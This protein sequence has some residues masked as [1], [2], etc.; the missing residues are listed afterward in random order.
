MQIE[1][2]GS[3]LVVEDIPTV[4][5]ALKG[6]LEEEG[7]E[8][9][10]A[11]DAEEAI[12]LIASPRERPFDFVIMDV[13]LTGNLDGI[14]G[15]REIR[16]RNKNVPIVYFTAYCDD[17]I[18]MREIKESNT[19]YEAVIDKSNEGELFDLL[20]ELVK[21]KAIA[22]EIKKAIVLEIDPRDM[23]NYLDLLIEASSRE[24]V[25]QALENVGA[26]IGIDPSSQNAPP[27]LRFLAYQSRD[28]VRSS[29]KVNPNTEESPTISRS[30]RLGFQLI[31]VGTV[32]SVG[33]IYFGF[34]IGLATLLYTIASFAV[35]IYSY[36]IE[37]KVL[38]LD[39][40]VLALIIVGLYGVATSGLFALILTN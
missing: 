1:S 14:E 4:R 30:L 15:A 23:S 29:N 20:N 6:A 8:V 3:I 9:Y 2:M 36:Q 40:R 32:L 31:T 35:C 26:D 7:Y 25:S 11:E 37:S 21:T 17:P 27:I 5:T 22:R 24:I 33:L 18:V 39:K 13:K 10:A 16:Q 38:V 28:S 12:E 19:K 34:R